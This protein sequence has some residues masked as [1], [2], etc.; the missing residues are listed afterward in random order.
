M[1]DR[2]SHGERVK[3]LLAQDQEIN[4]VQLKEFRMQLEQS[5]ESWEAKAKKVRRGIVISAVV[6]AGGLIFVPLF[7]SARTLL[8]KGAMSVVYGILSGA[9]V[10]ASL[11]SLLIGSALVALYFIK[12]APGLKRARFDVQTA[13]ILELQQQ[14]EQFRQDIEWRGK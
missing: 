1:P 10:T 12:Y 7:T 13:M 8:P 5:L 4:D 9:V 3:K 6:Y 2:E 14:V 11:A